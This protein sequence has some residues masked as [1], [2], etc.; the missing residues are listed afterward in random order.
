MNIVIRKPFDGNYIRS[1]KFGDAPDWYV[2]IAGYPHNGIDYPMMVWTPILA[3]DDGVV[4][5]AD[6]T[7]DSNGLG[8]NIRHAWGLSQYW[9]L[10]EVTA[11][12]GQ[13]VKKGD[14][15]GFSGATGWATGPHLHFGIRINDIPNPTMRNWNDPEPYFEPA[16]GPAQPPPE[17]NKAY[18]VKLGDSLWKIAEK[19]YGMGWL[20]P[21]IYEANKEKIKDPNLIYPFQK[22]VIPK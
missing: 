11:K 4:E 19:H 5:W 2:K 13:T 9:H 10:I 15:I 3:C 6:N 12:A 1:L 14:E 17:Q 20:W 18:L 16:A 7:P 21:R 8:I 22:L